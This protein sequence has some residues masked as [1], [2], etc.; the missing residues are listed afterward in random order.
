MFVCGTTSNVHVISPV[1]GGGFAVA[2]LTWMVTVPRHV[3][4]RN[5][6][7]PDGPVGVDSRPQD[8]ARSANNAT[9]AR[10]GLVIPPLLS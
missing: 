8:T 5:D 9:A 10:P 7:E 6:V 3:P 4:A 2:G 1:D